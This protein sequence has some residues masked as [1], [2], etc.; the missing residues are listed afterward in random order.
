M[1]FKSQITEGKFNAVFCLKIISLLFD[2]Q[3]QFKKD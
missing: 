1:I 2:S 3:N